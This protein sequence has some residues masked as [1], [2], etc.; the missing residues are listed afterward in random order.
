M[1]DGAGNDLKL[2]PGDTMTG[3]NGETYSYGKDGKITIQNSKTKPEETVTI[4]SSITK[5]EDGK[6]VVKFDEK[7]K[8]SLKVDNIYPTGTDDDAYLSVTGEDNDG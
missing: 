5:G 4:G 7:Y 8:T 6:S 2:E 3:P 1:Q